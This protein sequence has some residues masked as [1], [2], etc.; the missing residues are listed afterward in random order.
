MF[1]CNM[2]LD[3]S[4]ATS[5]STSIS[6]YPLQRATKRAMTPP[7]A[8]ALIMLL[9]L[10]LCAAGNGQICGPPAVPLNAKV[11]TITVDSQIAE[12]HYECDA[13]Y[14]LFGPSAVKCDR[15]TGWER[16][17]PFCG[18]NVA[19]RKP[20]NQSSYTRSGPA[21]Y[22]NDGKPGN[23]TCYDFHITKGEASTRRK[24]FASK[25]AMW[26]KS[27]PGARTSRTTTM[28]SRT[29][30]SSMEV[31]IGCG[32]MWAAIWTICTSSAS[33]LHCLAARRMPSKTPLSWAKS[34]LWARRSSTPAPRATRC[35]VRRNGSADS[36]ALGVAPRRPA[37][38]ISC[39][40]GGEWSSKTPSCRF[41]D[42]GAPARPNRGIAI[43]LNGTTTVNS[44]V[45]YECDE[46]HW[47]DGQSELYCTRDG[48]WSGEAPVCELVTC[49]TPS[50]PSGSFVIGYDYNVHSKIQYNCDP[51]HIMHGTPVLECLDSGEWSADAPY[52]EYI[53]CGTILPIPYGSHKYVTNTTYVGSEVVFSCSQSHKLSGVLKRTC[54]ESAV[55]SDASP[56]CEENIYDQ[57]PN[58]Q[59]YDAPYE[60]RTNDEV[61]EPEPVASNVIT[62]N[63]ISVR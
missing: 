57:I 58:E 44:V 16:D 40:L 41:V 61:Y 37:N 21:S 48:K 6:T 49:E 45:K 19:Y 26:C 59:F 62:I 10:A 47:L 25:L 9:L 38:I 1:C 11:R 7:N 22:A 52:C 42:C 4:V 43:L 14:E 15:R 5:T 32:T 51:G 54:L 33:T 17:L 12:A 8:M 23:K 60:M 2:L 55:W 3:A 35:S 50:V 24:P 53:D 20:V 39:G 56:K 63:G 29:A 34:S 46:D 28:A 31:A 13:G 36:M 27:P 18:V 30:W